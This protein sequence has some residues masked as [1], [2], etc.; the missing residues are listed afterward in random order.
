MWAPRRS[1]RQDARSGGRAAQTAHA[2]LSRGCTSAHQSAGCRA[3]SSRP[4][5]SR[6]RCR[7][8][9]PGCGRAA[10]GWR[11]SGTRRRGPPAS[12][13]SAP[14]AW[15]G[16]APRR[17]GRA[18]KSRQTWP[19]LPPHPTFLHE[20]D[21]IDTRRRWLEDQ[22]ARAA[23][24]HLPIG[25]RSAAQHAILHETSAQAVPWHARSKIEQHGD[26]AERSGVQPFHT[27]PGAAGRTPQACAGG[28][29]ASQ[30]PCGR[31]RGAGAKQQ[32]R[33]RQQSR[34]RWRF[35]AARRGPLPCWQCG[36][37]PR[38]PGG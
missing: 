12:H 7:C 26:I 32:Q 31:G 3:R 25:T 18:P 4:T 13:S 15:W 21:V 20:T 1:G 28:R 22:G 36:G 2:A 14:T 23:P 8:L 30:G 38:S 9:P 10:R 19:L 27:L 24:R 17:A 6:C 37:W 29:S 11:S 35:K 16:G 33:R 34:R 5:W